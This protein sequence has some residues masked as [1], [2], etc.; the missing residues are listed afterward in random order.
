[1]N[2]PIATRPL[3]YVCLFPA[4]ISFQKDQ[5]LFAFFAVDV[6]S[7]FAFNTGM[8]NQLNDSLVL[9]HIQL[10]IND[11]NFIKHRK[12]GFT[13]VLH[14]FQHLTADINTIIK[15]LNGNLIFNDP[16]VSKVFEP[17]LKLFYQNMSKRLQ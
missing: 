9:K 5:E 7:E 17:F 14:K 2:Y 16:F 10:L 6:F 11:P 12:N 8:E 4:D 13:L 3:E 15:P 1:M